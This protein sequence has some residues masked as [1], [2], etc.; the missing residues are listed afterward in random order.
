MYATRIKLDGET[1]IDT[2]ANYIPESL[3]SVQQFWEDPN[4][5]FVTNPGLEKKVTHEGELK[6]FIGNTVVFR[7]RPEVQTALEELQQ[8][9]YKTSAHLLAEPLAASTFHVTLHDLA[10]GPDSA[11]TRQWMAAVEPEAKRLVGQLKETYTQP[12]LFRA[13]W[14]F[15]MVNT[16]VVLGLAPMF[17]CEQQLDEMYEAF[18]ELVP[19]NYALTPH[20]TMAYLKPGSYTEQELAP[21]R[22]QLQPVKLTFSVR[23]QDLEFQTFSSMNSYQTVE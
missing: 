20:I 23:M 18:H 3:P 11:E 4:F 5:R 8:E 13:T 10:N 16:S 6:P 7:L 14:L 9:L 21:L 19:L 12:M 17:G 22:E 2:L 15:N 1:V